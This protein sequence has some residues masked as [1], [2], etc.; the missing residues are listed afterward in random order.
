MAKKKNVATVPR[1]TEAK[2]PNCLAGRDLLKIETTAGRLCG[3]RWYVERRACG[4]RAV[5]KRPQP[6]HQGPRRRFAHMGLGRSADSF[7]IK[8]LT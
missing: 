8:Q 1:T 7:L 6:K 5:P 4:L 2:Y 3:Q